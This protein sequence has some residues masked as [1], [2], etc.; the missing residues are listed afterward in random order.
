[1]LLMWSDCRLFVRYTAPSSA[2]AQDILQELRWFSKEPRRSEVDA[3]RQNTRFQYCV[4]IV[5]TIK[6]IYRLTRF[7]CIAIMHHSRYC[8]CRVIQSPLC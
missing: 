1:M 6:G 8:T 5:C 3:H 4:L 7:F 2:V